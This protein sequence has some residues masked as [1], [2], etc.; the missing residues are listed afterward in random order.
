[1]RLERHV[2][3]E[4]EDD[5]DDGRGGVVVKHASSGRFGSADGEDRGEGE[6]LPDAANRSSISQLS[7]APDR[8]ASSS[9]AEYRINALRRSAA[10]AI[11]GPNLTPPSLSSLEKLVAGDTERVDLG[12]APLLHAL[13]NA[14]ESS[15][16]WKRWPFF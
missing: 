15:L 4:E 8:K 12:D 14:N 2:G 13:M 3:V 7:T 10:G 16:S 1:M 11:N 9:S 6:M 5:D